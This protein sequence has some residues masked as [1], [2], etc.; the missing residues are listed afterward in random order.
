MK[1]LFTKALCY[2]SFLGLLLSCSKKSEQ[3]FDGKNGTL[4]I[5]YPSGKVKIKKEYK[6]GYLDG[7]FTEYY[8]NGKIESQIVYKEHLKQGPFQEFYEDGTLKASMFFKNSLKDSICSYYYKNGQLKRQEFYKKGKQ[9]GLS[10]SFHEN[11]KLASELNFLKGKK[12]GTQK[13]YYESGQLKSVTEF[14][15]GQPGIGLEEYTREGKP[16]HHDLKIIVDEMNKMAYDELYFYFLR[17]SKPSDDDNFIIG[18]LEN[19]RFLPSS[20]SRGELLREKN[21][22][23]KKYFVPRNAFIQDQFTLIATTRTHFGNTLIVTKNM[24]VSLNNFTY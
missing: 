3:S 14:D 24:N 1:R 10:K 23:V 11:G 6:D 4:I 16:I 8:E 17:L 19:G 22:W 12:H 9:D 2:L 5:K 21:V 13:H 18:K 15:N 20:Y 7:L